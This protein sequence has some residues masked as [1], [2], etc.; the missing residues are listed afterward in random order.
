M[1]FEHLSP[2][3]YMGRSSFKNILKLGHIWMLSKFKI[4]P[5][6]LKCISGIRVVEFIECLDLQCKVCCKN[7]VHKVDHILNNTRVNQD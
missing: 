3:N 1:D 2:E 6:V 5:I 7:H 4:N